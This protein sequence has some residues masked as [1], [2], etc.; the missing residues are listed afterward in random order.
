MDTLSSGPSILTHLPL[1]FIDSTLGFTEDDHLRAI[2]DAFHELHKPNYHINISKEEK[3]DWLRNVDNLLSVLIIFFTNIDDLLDSD[4]GSETRVTDLDVNW[5]NAAVGSSKFLYFLGPSS[6]P[7]QGLSVRS[8]LVQDLSD[9]LFKTHILNS[10]LVECKDRNHQNRGHII[11][12]TYKHSVSLIQDEES[13][14]VEFEYSHFQKVKQSARS[15]DQNLNSSLNLPL[16]IS[17]GYSSKDCKARDFA[18][19]SKLSR[20]LFDLHHKF[21]CRS[22]D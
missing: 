6:A 4:V 2:V 14:S 7:H 18:R 1:K 19:L 12:S 21:S 15:G 22:H 20:L 9:V 17:F 10:K 3:W 11:I 16:L 8:H 5:Q 13:N